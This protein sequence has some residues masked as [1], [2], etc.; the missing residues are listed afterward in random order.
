MTT[1]RATY[2]KNIS[3]KK[4]YVKNT[5]LLRLFL[6]TRN[7]SRNNHGVAIKPWFLKKTGYMEKG[8]QR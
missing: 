4:T 5:K 6:M 8:I 3:I 2:V 1:R 7:A